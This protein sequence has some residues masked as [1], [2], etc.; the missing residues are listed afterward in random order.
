MN[1][2]AKYFKEDCSTYYHPMPRK[3]KKMKKQVRCLA[4][5]INLAANNCTT[6]LQTALYVLLQ[7]QGAAARVV[8]IHTEA[9]PFHRCFGCGVV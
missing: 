5:E 6:S 8:I 1:L 7:S 2:M 3:L 9:L 4:S